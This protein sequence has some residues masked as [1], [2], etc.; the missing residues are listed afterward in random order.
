MYRTGDLGR[1]LPNGRFEI[2][3]RFDNQV[4]LKGYRIELEEVADAMMQ[5]PQVVSAAAIVKDKTHLVAYYSPS[6]ADLESLQNLVADTLPV[7]MVPAVWVG[8]DAMPMNTNGK[9]DKKLLE[10]YDVSIDVEDLATANEIQVASI[11]AQVLNVDLKTIGRRTSFFALGGDSTTAIKAVA[12]L[13]Q[14]GM[15]I[16]VA[17]FMKAAMLWRVASAVATTVNDTWA[18]V[19]LPETVFA[20]IHEKWSKSLSLTNYTAYPVT[21][22]QAGMIYATLQNH[23]AYTLQSPFRLRSMADKDKFHQAYLA[24][25]SSNEDLRTTFV[26]TSSGIYQTIRNDLNEIDISTV[27]A[28]S[29][30]DFLTADFSR[31]FEIG[32][33]HFVRLTF[34]DVADE[35]YVVLTIHHALYDGWSLPM[36]LGDLMDAYCGH[37]ITERPSFRRVV[38]YIEAQ[39]KAVTEAHWR[40]Y[41]EGLVVTPIG[42]AVT[43][44]DDAFLTD[45]SREDSL[46]I[47]SS[48]P[49]VD[50]TKT[51]H[52]NGATAADVAKMAWATTLRKY[53]R[54]DDV[55]FGQVM[56]NRDIPVQGAERYIHTTSSHSPVYPLELLDHF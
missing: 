17:Q 42:S 26:V 20:Q 3:G 27:S 7:Y 56:A 55:L 29:L 44:K 6:D 53:T 33:K 10:S 9:I 36:L 45:L 34:V 5:H 15:F 18:K 2:L 54:K 35:F 28:S 48:V 38:D 31:G 1:L 52:Q 39:D 25:V 22:L 47:D 49:M 50:L 51:A 21:P 41:M 46:S 32:A 30:D 40:S 37:D 16:T 8:L 11:W 43:L 23:N 4:K 12:G 14:V 19:T 24:V 13:K